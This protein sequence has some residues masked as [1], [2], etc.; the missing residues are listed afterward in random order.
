[1]MSQ[2]AASGENPSAQVRKEFSRAVGAVSSGR[3]P[4][5][6]FPR[7]ATLRFVRLLARDVPRESGGGTLKPLNCNDLRRTR[8]PAEFKHINKRWKRKQQ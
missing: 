2:L 4:G 5:E 1:M 8:L 7:R 3:C 6:P